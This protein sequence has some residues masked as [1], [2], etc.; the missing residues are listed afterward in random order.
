MPPKKKRKLPPPL[1]PGIAA[2]HIFDNYEDHGTGTIKNGHVL[3]HF[4]KSEKSVVKTVNSLKS[5]CDLDVSPSMVVSLADR[6]INYYKRLTD[7]TEM[8][9]FKDL[10]DAMF[11]RQPTPPAENDVS[12]GPS[13]AL[14]IQLSTP[15]TLVQQ[16]ATPSTSE[17]LE[18]PT[19]A[20]RY[21]EKSTP[22]TLVP[23]PKSTPAT[24]VPEPATPSTSDTLDAPA[25]APRQRM[26]LTPR[27]K[28]LYKR[29]NF[30]SASK[31]ELVKTN[32]DLKKRL[33]N[34]KKVIN[35]ALRR[36][37]GIIDNRD[38]EIQFLKGQPLVIELAETKRELARS[39]DVHKKLK[40]YRDNQKKVLASKNILL[41][42]K[43]KDVND[44]V[45]TLQNDKVILQEEI[46]E[47]KSKG[48][49][50]HL[51]MD[52]NKTYSTMARM[53]VFDHIINQVP[54]VNIPDLIQQSLLRTGHKPDN[55]PQRSAVELMA[56]ELG[57]ISELQTAETIIENDNVTMGFDATTQEGVH[58][59]SI[60]FTTEKGCCAASV[61][62][63]PGGMATDYSNHICDTVDHLSEAYAYFN[64]KDVQETK[65]KIIGNIANSM[66]DRC[67]ANHAALR[68]VSSEWKKPINE[69]NCH[70]HPLDSFATTTRTALKK[71]ETAR[72]KVFGSDCVAANLI[73]Q[74]NKLRYKDGKGD[75]RG[76]IS[77][78]D[79]HNVPRCILP[80]YRGNRLH[81]LF[82]ISGVLTERYEFFVE[83]FT[84]G[85]PCGGLRSAILHDF[86]SEEA[87]MELQV[88]GLLGKLLTGPWMRKFYTSAEKEIHH[89]EG[90]EVVRQVLEK[91]KVAA[92]APEELLT[93]DVDFFG[94]L[95]VS[96]S[97]LSALRQGAS[98]DINAFS[99]M[100]K[101]SVKAVI[102]VIERQYSTYFT[103]DLNQK[104]REE[105]KS[106]RSHNIDAEEI[107]GMF[108]AAQKR[109]PNATLCFLSCRMRSK[110][111][112]TVAYLDSLDD[113]RRE[114][115]LR[116]AVS[117]GR[118]QRNTRKQRQKDLRVEMIK[119]QDDKRQ[120]KNQ[121]ERKNL[122]KQLMNEPLDTVLKDFPNMSDADV[123]KLQEMLQGKLVGRKIVHVWYEDGGLMTYNGKLKK[124][125][126]LKAGKKY[127][128]AYWAPSEDYD[129]AT[130]YEMSVFELAA[131]FI[132][133]D[134]IICD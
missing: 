91:L 124:L 2:Q 134:L 111:N 61:D 16:S 53:M 26:Q 129:D 6:S 62:E 37:T 131:D 31:S 28:K 99:N 29:L 121:S 25:S 32:R 128:T 49:T 130:D 24:L 107:M 36:K 112:R 13:S 60:H 39:R 78:L 123:T 101:V 119:R 3:W 100:M 69:L 41:Q 84:S 19:S 54:T 102:G 125:R 83:L 85:T 1:K 51:K 74:I 81:V 82:H 70:L 10:C 34:P 45:G 8:E 67:A 92:E 40:Q 132:Q 88:L 105:T 5:T 103:W 21:A 76:F 22:A 95:L 77:Y 30:L 48:T 89:V 106:A 108:S 110:K 71:V 72:G 109:A 115:V 65:K 63:L 55:I 35:Q 46:E 14:D 75:P 117:F 27:K 126:A 7:E 120:K 52:D 98:K 11:L 4:L 127:K 42:H 93:T 33:K 47:L 58:I 79:K 59:N 94:D 113:A 104:L 97:T 116:K 44:T 20:P 122:E 50:V 87:K 17:S 96:G 68:N 66:S 38:E 57:A 80:R 86:T 114:I 64:D 56:R 43:L 90:I 18:A 9:K 23:G 12:P 133:G 15:A 73:L 118:K